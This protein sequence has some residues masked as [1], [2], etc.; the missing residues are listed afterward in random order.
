MKIVLQSMKLKGFIH[1][2]AIG[3]CQN[4][5]VFLN[6]ESDMPQQMKYSHSKTI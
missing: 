1:N 6:I 2:V 3:F 5:I 4:I